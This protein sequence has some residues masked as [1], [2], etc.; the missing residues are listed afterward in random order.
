M[1]F[2][3]LVAC[4]VFSPL[5]AACAS[6]PERS[7]GSH[8]ATLQVQ[9]VWAPGSVYIE[10]SYSYIRVERD[11]DEVV[12]VRLTNAPSPR[13]TLRLEP[14][15]YRLVSFQRPCDGNCGTLDPPTDECARSLEAFEGAILE[16]VV[17]I[18][19]GRGC[20]IETRVV[21]A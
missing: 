20:T 8:R 17:R 3:V 14:G 6:A 13:S 2:A 10:G 21:G 7:V 5:L 12:Q 18:A 11:G 1:R 4:A 16:A 9:Q 15:S 19:P